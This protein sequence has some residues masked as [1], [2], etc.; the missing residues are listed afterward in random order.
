VGGIAQD[1]R[2]KYASIH[3]DMLCYAM[4]KDEGCKESRKYI[5]QRCWSQS[6]G[7][8][9]LLAALS[10]HIRNSTLSTD[11]IDYVLPRV[12]SHS[13]I[14]HSNKTPKHKVL[15]EA[16]KDRCYPLKLRKTSKSSV[17]S[18]LQAK[19]L[20]SPDSSQAYRPAERLN[21]YCWKAIPPP[22]LSSP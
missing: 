11:R 20:S 21:L 17:I 8:S 13:N 16:L 7:E 12:P 4:S 5:K 14:T 18:Q 22:T 10:S 9:S 2:R 1:T 19:N 6:K 15:S 3:Y